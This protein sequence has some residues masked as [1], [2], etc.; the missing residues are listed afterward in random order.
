V[1]G[2]AGQ[3]AQAQDALRRLEELYRHQHVDPIVMVQAHIGMGKI[4]EAFAWLEKAYSEHS[5]V[6]TYLK[7]DPLFDPLRGDRRFQDLL[8][9][10]GLDK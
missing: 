6:I 3:Q 2:R 1:Y 9:R 7:V 5:T 10:V 4:D 8:H